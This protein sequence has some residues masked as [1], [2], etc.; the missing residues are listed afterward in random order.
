M[1]ALGSGAYS[2]AVGISNTISGNSLQEPL[3]QSIAKMVKTRTRQK[4]LGNTLQ[5]RFE[6]IS[7]QYEDV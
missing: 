7:Q 4:Y 6:G 5:F 2:L 1:T 3:E